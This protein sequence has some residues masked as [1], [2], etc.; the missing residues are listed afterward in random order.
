VLGWSEKQTCTGKAETEAFRQEM[1]EIFK[2]YCRGYGT[3]VSVGQVL[4]E[5]LQCIRLHKVRIDVNYATLVI[6]VLCLHG[7]G[8]VLQPNY[9][10]LDAAKPLLKVRSLP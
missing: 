5:V 9:N 10:I 3:N 1:D 2:V 4:I 6:N 7:L 8:E